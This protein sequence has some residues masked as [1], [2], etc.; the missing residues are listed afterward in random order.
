MLEFYTPDCYHNMVLY[1][2][3]EFKGCVPYSSVSD[4]TD[5]I[6]KGKSFVKGIGI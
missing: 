1:V 3:K 4:P 6:F 5:F 2:G